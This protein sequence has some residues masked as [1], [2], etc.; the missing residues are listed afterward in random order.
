MSG[1]DQP[2]SVA[3]STA[4]R[5]SR[6]ALSAGTSCARSVASEIEASSSASRIRCGACSFSSAMEVTSVLRKSA[7]LVAGGVGRADRSG[8]AA[9]PS[10]ASAR[11]RPRN[12]AGD[13]AVIRQKAGAYE[14]D[15]RYPVRPLVDE[16]DLLDHLARH[17]VAAQPEAP[18]EAVAPSNGFGTRLEDLELG[19]PVEPPLDA[20]CDLLA[21]GAYLR[22][23]WQQEARTR[24]G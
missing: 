21:S 9:G 24:R 12:V 16:G 10:V 6:R 14:V 5:A 15:R 22:S 3:S 7:S 13:R 11:E 2:A 17:P 1:A 8:P 18:I 20:G 4:S 19:G 23:A